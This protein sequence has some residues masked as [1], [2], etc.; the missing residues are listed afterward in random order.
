MH[1]WIRLDSGR[2]VHAVEQNL[3][4]AFARADM[5]VALRFKPEDC[6]VVPAETGTERS[7]DEE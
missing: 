6:M 3:G 7:Q 4:Q 5:P 2:L 1:L